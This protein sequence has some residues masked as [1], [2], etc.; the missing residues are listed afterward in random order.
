MTVSGFN[1]RH[2]SIRA[3]SRNLLLQCATVRPEEEELMRGIITLATVTALS[4]AGV[5]AFANS[6]AANSEIA[7]SVTI[8]LWQLHLQADIEHMPV[9]TVADPI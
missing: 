4:I 7:Q 1:W 3:E 8:D 2:A 6:P 5:Y 9:L